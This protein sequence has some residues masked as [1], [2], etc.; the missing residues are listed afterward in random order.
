MRLSF[1]IISLLLF[2]SCKAQDETIFAEEFDGDILNSA[3]WN[4]DL[5]NGCPDLCGW[6]NNELQF[7][8]QES[9]A[10]KNGNLNIE[11]TFDNGMYQSG[12]ITTKGKVEFQYG[13][14]EIRAQLPQ[15]T[16]IWPAMWLLGNDIDSI[17]WPAC[18]EIDM[19]EFAGKDPLKL[20]T[21]LHTPAS[22]GNSVN[23]K[24]NL[25]ENLTDE[26]HVFK[27]TWTEDYIEFF[28]DGNSLYKFNPEIKNEETWPFNKPYYLIINTAVGG[29][30][31]GEEVDNAIFPQNLKIDYIK[32][33]N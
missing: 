21:T 31:G 12:K 29:T 1:F 3:H 27:M 23:T 18:G 10:L 8:T 13:T 22:H 5:G 33:Y 2:T 14:V 30:F 25:V 6:G 4:Y 20:H 19:M 26:Y 28:I 16:G 7:Y 17:G 9:V 15:G 11:T 32:I 24:M